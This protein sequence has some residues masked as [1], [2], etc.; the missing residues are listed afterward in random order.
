M[1]G[2][3]A[4]GRSPKAFRRWFEGEMRVLAEFQINLAIPKCTY[5]YFSTRGR[6]YVFRGAINIVLV[7]GRGNN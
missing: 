1:K 6:G 4:L 5:G 7:E 2:I 3:Y